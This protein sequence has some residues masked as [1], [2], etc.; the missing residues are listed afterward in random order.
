MDLD[1]GP[2]KTYSL[3]LTRLILTI[4]LWTFRDSFIGP[5]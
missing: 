3:D 2:F 4:N 5:H 1:F